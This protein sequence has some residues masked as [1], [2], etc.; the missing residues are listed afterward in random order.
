M[1]DGPGV[2]D[3]RNLRVLH[4]RLSRQLWDASRTMDLV[5]KVFPKDAS[6]R[7]A[8]KDVNS[9]LHGS[10][11]LFTHIRSMLDAANITD[12]VKAPPPED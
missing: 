9:A 8:R 12:P 2:S 6:V 3:L 11:L 5:L 4:S 7:R 1:A 10:Y